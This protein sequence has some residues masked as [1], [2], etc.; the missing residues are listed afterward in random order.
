MFLFKTHAC[1]RAR[2]HVCAW[3]PI[4]IRCFLIFN[5]H[6]CFSARFFPERA[7]R[8][9]CIWNIF[10]IYSK[11]DFSFK[12]CSSLSLDCSLMELV[13]LFGYVFHPSSHLMYSNVVSFV[14]ASIPLSDCKLLRPW[15][16]VFFSCLC[17]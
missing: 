12:L 13:S 14:N 5:K 9:S 6:L 15:N 4:L 10:R 1:T 8:A 11:T 3:A 17:Q 2:M 16:C 7:Y